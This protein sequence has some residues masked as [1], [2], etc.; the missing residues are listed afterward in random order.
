[1]NSRDDPYFSNIA[2]DS[3]LSNSAQQRP[4]K[5]HDQNVKRNILNLINISTCTAENV[6]EDI[7]SYREILEHVQKQFKENYVTS[8]EYKLEFD[9]SFL[10]Y[11]IHNF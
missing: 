3:N 4:I 1:M 9:V 10:N 8:D 7:I 6:M 5:S 2:H 11:E